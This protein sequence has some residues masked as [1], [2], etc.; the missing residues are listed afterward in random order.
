MRKLFCSF[1]R[2]SSVALENVG[3]FTWQQLNEKSE[4]ALHQIK[5]KFTDQRRESHAYKVNSVR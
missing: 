5:L 4:S 3:L 2:V 1:V